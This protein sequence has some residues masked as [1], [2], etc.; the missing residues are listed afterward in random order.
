M[1]NLEPTYLRYVYDGLLRE[2]F[3]ADNAAGLP[4]G[5]VGAYDQAFN[6]AVPV[7]ERQGM[8]SELAV[9]ALLKKEASTV[10]VAR[11]LG[12]EA[13]RIADQIARFS[14]WFNSPEPGKYQLYHERLKVYLL[15]K[16]SEQELYELQEKLI[17]FLEQAMAE[18]KADEVELYALE[19]LHIHLSVASQLGKHYDRLHKYVNRESLWRRQ[20]QL[21]KG[22]EWSQK[23]VQQGIKEGARRQHE[24]NTIR[25]AVNSVKLMTQEQ[26]SAEDILNLLNEGDYPAALKRAESWEGKRQFKLYLLMLHDLT[27]GESKQ[28]EFRKEAC[29]PQ[30]G[31]SVRKSE[32][33]LSAPG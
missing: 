23:A 12:V 18:Q 30:S 21:S 33:I 13:E 17:T 1:P 29:K 15:Q 20:I 25:S 19:H 16:L 31:C 2:T 14:S 5:L 3:Q 9:W 26:N 4:D 10:F 27:I 28:A 11:V 22:Y 8:M 24:L 7:A 32:P 6:A